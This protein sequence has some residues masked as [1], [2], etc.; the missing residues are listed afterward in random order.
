EAG[1]LLPVTW[2]TFG[3]SGSTLPIWT[4]HPAVID[5]L[6]GS[7]LI[8]ALLLSWVL[9]HKIARQGIQWPYHLGS[10]VLGISLWAVIGV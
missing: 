9:T 10:L 1:Q 7:T 6:Q 3:F 8:L 5:F 4:A 2:A